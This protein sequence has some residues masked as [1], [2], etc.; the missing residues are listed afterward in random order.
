[1]E[2]NQSNAGA[3]ALEFARELTGKEYIFGGTWPRDDGTDCDGLVVWA[4]GQVGVTLVRPTETTYHEDPM[5]DRSKPNE[6]GDLLF[7]RGDPSEVNPGHVVM[8]AAPG[9]VFEAEETG[10]LIGQFPFDTDAWEFRT[11]PALSLPEAPP[12]PP[13]APPKPMPPAVGHPRQADLTKAGLVEMAD[14]AQAEEAEINGWALWY[15]SKTHFVAQR[16]A[17]P[18]GVALYA[19]HS[20]TTKK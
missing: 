12:P 16:G 19:N 9:E 2:Y 7:I 17:K 6:V 15:W 1:M 8:Y 5:S 14:V 20:W 4:Y 13:P 10:T 11:R 18:E 3:A